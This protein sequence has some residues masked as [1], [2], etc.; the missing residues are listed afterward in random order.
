MEDQ[1]KDSRGNPQYD[2]TKAAQN[3]KCKSERK[4]KTEAACWN[5]KV[6]YVCI[7][8]VKL[9]IQHFC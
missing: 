6:M 7:E 2:A 8:I 1:C 4:M 5:M 9:L 3:A